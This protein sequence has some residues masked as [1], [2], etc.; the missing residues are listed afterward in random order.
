MGDF[1]AISDAYAIST[2][3]KSI[4]TVN[5]DDS[6]VDCILV[7]SGIILATGSVEQIHKFWG[8]YNP[9]VSLQ[10]FQ[11]PPG[12]IIVPGLADAH[13]HILQWGDKVRLPLESCVSI[14]DVLVKIKL[15]LLAHPDVLHDR[16][17]WIVGIGWDQTK[18][19][20][21]EFPTADD[22]DREPLLR[23]RLV[24]LVRVDFHAYWVS[25]SIL[26]KLTDLPD[27]VG[28]GIIVRHEDGKPTG[29]FVDTAMDLI[30]NLRPA[31]TEVET[32]ESFEVAMRDALRV[33]LTSIHDAASLPNEIAF[34]RRMAD[35]GRL[36]IKI[37]VMGSSPSNDYCQIPRLLNYG[38][39]KRLTVRSVKLFADGALGSWGAALIA[40]YVDKP[41]TRGL[42]RTP[43]ETLRRLAEQSYEDG[44]QVNIHAIG[45][46]ANEIVLDIF[47][48]ILS[49]PGADV[50]MW[51][52]RIE[53]AQTF[54]PSDLE[55]IGRLGVYSQRMRAFQLRQSVCDNI[56]VSRRTSDMNYAESRLGPDRMRGAYAYQTLLQASPGK[57]LPLGS[58]FPVEG[59]NPL[60][61]FYAAIARRSPEG[62]SPHGPGG[63]YPAEALT[64]TQALRGMTRDAAYACFT[65]DTR[66]QLAPG[67]A[68]D[69]VE[70]L[71]TKVLA[72]VVDG[73]VAYG[74]L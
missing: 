29:V 60:L 24:L 61:G 35:E 72:T 39:H 62:T 38:P 70:I 6:I 14:D 19:P 47:E 59:M 54:Q 50:D 57:R 36:P 8:A 51:R 22:L 23:G 10:V 16:T 67:F 1:A 5:E 12:S 52:P 41:D 9:D 74:S 25:N 64:R 33:G 15:Y 11:T 55:R 3:P 37:Y 42:L 28:G 43:P 34:F 71:D 65:E 21:R 18:W 48:D 30:E 32:F 31:P 7:E 45:D 17:R 2:P 46:R 53:H 27:I 63:W 40:P 20:G 26:S 4:Y 44:L 68:A 66:G 73:Q 49:K 13:G 56:D 69:F 58:D